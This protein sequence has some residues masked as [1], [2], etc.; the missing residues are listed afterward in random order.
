MSEEKDIKL[1]VL[2]PLDKQTDE[3][4]KK[5]LKHI[6]DAFDNDEVINLAL[7]GVYGSGKSTIIKSFKALHPTIKF[8]DISLAS[9]KETGEYEQF[10]DQIQLNILQQIIYSQKA[11]KLPESRINRIREIN[12]KDF[13]NWLKLVSS[14][15]LIL[16][17]Y[18]LLNFYEY[19]LNP[20]NWNKSLMF[21]WGAFVTTLLFLFS[22]GVIYVFISKGLYN[23]KINKVSIKGEVGLSDGIENKDF[24]NKYIDEILYFFE[25]NEINIV[26]IEDLDRFNTTEIYRTLREINLILN[27]YL[28][29]L[30]SNKSKVLFL[31]AIKD[32][33]FLNELDR[34][35]FF[36]LIIPTI[37]FVNFSNSKNILN[38]ELDQIF[39]NDKTN[40]P[41][42]DFINIAS[43]FITDNR[44]LLNVLNEFIVYREQQKVQNEEFNPEILLALIMYKNL[45]P[46]DFAK[47][48]TGNSVIDIA[49]S[50][51][52]KF[53]SRSIQS[54]NKKI[55]DIQEDIQIVKNNNLHSI[56]ELN[57]IYL[58][59]IKNHINDS[60]VTSLI[61]NEEKVS[62]E[63]L[64]NDSYD[65]SI[66]NS[67]KIKSDSIYN[68]TPEITLKD[69]DNILGYNYSDRYNDILNKNQIIENN[70]AEVLRLRYDIKK[71]ESESLANIY[72]IDSNSD[73]FIKMWDELYMRENLQDHLKIY[74]D[75]FTIVFLKNG[76]I[77]E[78]YREYIT[79]FQKGG[80]NEKD[81]EFKINILSKIRSPKDLDYNL[82]H[83][84]DLIQ[85]IP[86]IYF[87]D[88][89]ILN[90]Q[91][92]DFILKNQEKY[93]EQYK[94][95]INTLKKWSKRSQQLMLK[96]IDSDKYSK[97][98]LIKELS[99]NW[100]EMWINIVQTDLIE[101]DIKQ[102][103]FLLLDNADIKSLIGLNQ[104]MQLTN[105]I[106]KH[107]DILFR[108]DLENKKPLLKQ[109]LS[110]K[111][112]DVKFKDLNPLIGKHNSILEFIYNNNFYE[113]SYKNLEILLK[114]KLDNFNKEEFDNLNFTYIYEN[115][116]DKL[117]DYLNEDDLEL[118][119][120][121]ISSNL[122]NQNDKEELILKVVNKKKIEINKRLEFIQKQRSKINDLYEIGDL[123][124]FSLVF[125]YNKIQSTWKNIFNYYREVNDIFDDDLSEY[126]NIEENYRTLSSTKLNDTVKKEHLDNFVKS[127]LSANKLNTT[128]YEMLLDSLPYDYSILELDYKLIDL[129]KVELLINK[130]IISLDS[131]N[132]DSI[133]NIYPDLHIKLLLRSWEDYIEFKENNSIDIIDKIKILQHKTLSNEQKSLII[134]NDLNVDDMQNK[135]LANEVVSFMLNNTSQE[136]YS[137][138][139]LSLY[140]L[141]MLLIH[142]FP[143]DQKIKLVNSSKYLLNDKV[144][145]ELRKSLPKP[146]S[147]IFPQTQLLFEDNEYNREFIS[148]LQ[149]LNIA[150]KSN[151]SKKKLRVWFKNF[152]TR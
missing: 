33:I 87:E 9:F 151:P 125:K 149:K 147:G 122:S 61:Y 100:K 15:T 24:L 115:K 17:T 63:T 1:Q 8:L 5:Y 106:S 27:T 97:E 10:K 116:V 81:H 52:N 84:D 133:K 49:F 46:K 117:I 60:Y 83:I 137:K 78:D 105:Y 93:Q 94:A 45:R 3:R 18:F 22:L 103:L 140:E 36:D 4:I 96:F 53:I 150:G 138:E 72:K 58:Y 108:F 64:I 119:I 123:N 25:K 143:V 113:I 23:S 69:I 62:F 16:T 139:I 109:I 19:Q 121:N 37:P 6:K 20:N 128:S 12:F 136:S 13:K 47:F 28:K 68:K 145:Y 57:T 54:L 129:N 31:Y 112:L 50:N 74:D 75:P 66:Y 7:T 21:S 44:I 85:E 86:L 51:K 55:E 39:T 48:H 131:N 42:K 59:Y 67:E 107:I 142:D 26:V 141:K 32:D 98:I 71:L 90:L 132:F 82:T 38:K 101:T 114:N 148:I 11:D 130:N 65:L 110:K 144:M 135:E 91:L 80:L 146:Y 29:N 79:I 41:T 35:K 89:R 73:E 120:N 88:D 30:N 124:F 34:T 152:R 40:K 127:L 70:E 2:S 14:L 99:I 104:D 95:T 56:K 134:K 77:N 118:Y 43:S 102:I 76:F 111:G 126:L 92:I